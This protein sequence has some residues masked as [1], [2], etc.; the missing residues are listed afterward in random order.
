[1]R[2]AATAT[3]GRSR[4]VMATVTEPVPLMIGIIIMLAPASAGADCPCDGGAAIDRG[5]DDVAGGAMRA[6]RFTSV[7]VMSCLD[8]GLTQSVHHMLPDD[9][10]QKQGHH[11]DASCKDGA[12]YRGMAVRVAEDAPFGEA[13]V[14]ERLVEVFG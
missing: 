5:D 8:F 6:G 10:T 3:I 2:K 1:A 13:I 11:G 12:L 7:V 4:W 14:A 9:R